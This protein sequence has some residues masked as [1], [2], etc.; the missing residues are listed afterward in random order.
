MILKQ[1][2]N[3]GTGV[4]LPSSPMAGGESGYGFP[5]ILQGVRTMPVS[6]SAVTN[7]GTPSASGSC[8]DVIFLMYV[9]SRFEGL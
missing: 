4:S 7:N 5:R 1:N 2:M 8:F 3:H 6:E 9:V